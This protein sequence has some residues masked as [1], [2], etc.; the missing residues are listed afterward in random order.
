MR[1]CPRPQ[2][3]CCHYVTKPST[4]KNCQSYVTNQLLACPYLPLPLLSKTSKPLLQPPSPSIRPQVSTPTLKDVFQAS[5]RSWRRKRE[6]MKSAWPPTPASIDPSLVLMGEL[7]LC[8]RFLEGTSPFVSGL[9]VKCS[10]RKH[11]SRTMPHLRCSI[12]KHDSRTMPHLRCSVRKHDIRTMPHLRCSIRKHNS[13]TKP[14]WR[15]SIRKHNSRTKP[16]WRCSIRKHD[17]RTMLHLRCSVRKHDSRT[18]P[19]LRC[20]LRNHDSR[21]MPH[22]RCSVRK[23]DSRIIYA[24][25]EVFSTETRQ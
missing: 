24:T 3:L 9:T 12:R 11:D 4:H 1:C 5:Y 16:H 22:L 8:Q 14:H 20:L 23:H 25:L 2:T 18:V 10:V 6:I 13:R 17:S 7:Q 15:C 21:T 19:D